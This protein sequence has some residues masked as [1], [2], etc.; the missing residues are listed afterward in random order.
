MAI[1][2]RLA[3]EIQLQNLGQEFQHIL[4][5]LER[6][7]AQSPLGAHIQELLGESSLGGLGLSCVGLEKESMV[8]LLAWLFGVDE[9]PAEMLFSA[10]VAIN[11]KVH[12]DRYSATL[13]SCAATEY[14]DAAGLATAL[15]QLLKEAAAARRAVHITI[16]ER[17]ALQR[18]NLCIWT[19]TL[20]DGLGVAPFNEMMRATSVLIVA[21]PVE[22]C[23]NLDEKAELLDLVSGMA[24]VWPVVSD[25][26]KEGVRS[27]WYEDSIFS[28]ALSKL[29]ASFLKPEELYMTPN[30]IR[31]SGD[32]ARRMVEGA[33]TARRIAG[34]VEALGDHFSSEMS[35]ITALRAREERIGRSL[36][37]N[38]GNGQERDQ[39][40]ELRELIDKHF[41]DMDATIQEQNRKALLPAGNVNLAVQRVLEDLRE[42]DIDQE[43]GHSTIKLTLQREFQ[44]HLLNAAKSELNNQYRDDMYVL[45]TGFSTCRDAV[46]AKLESLMGAQASVAQ[47][48]FDE[49]AI[50]RLLRDAMAL[51]L[52]YRSEM[53]KRGGLERLGQGR[54]AVLGVMGI[55]GL[56]AVMTGVSATTILK[57]YP[58]LRKALIVVFIVVIPYT[59]IMWRKEDS[60]RLEKELDRVR[61]QLSIEV[62]RLIGEIQREKMTRIAETMNQARRDLQKR[63]ETILR[64][65]LMSRTEKTNQ[66]R[67]DNRDKQRTLEQR[68]RDL[69]GLSSQISKLKQGVADVEFNINKELRDM[70]KEMKAG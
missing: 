45:N 5:Q 38:S 30:F 23:L 21:G 25:A 15:P 42:S 39:I 67:Q 18:V 52:K 9:L 33:R 47:T 54:Q 68:S 63:S 8:V 51:E 57:D 60:A 34:S 12:S 41:H 7:Q 50:W 64:E 35:R 31:D 58:Y 11:V 20:K 22:Y 19:G 62:K 16:P 59:F 3:P 2:P 61:D 26:R 37:K 27:A 40:E 29:P 56:I 70:C 6:G 32:A 17:A 66:Q 55:L 10:D 43:V 36:E 48:P 44:E 13:I 14:T 4:A 1:A 24:A 46:K 28:R 49:N 65:K 69:Q 53:P